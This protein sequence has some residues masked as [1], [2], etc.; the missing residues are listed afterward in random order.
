MFLLQVYTLLPS[1]G[2]I[3]LKCDWKKCQ[4]SC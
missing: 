2:T 3:I 4:Y 1:Y